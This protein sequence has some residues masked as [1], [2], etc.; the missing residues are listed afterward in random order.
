MKLVIKKEVEQMRTKLNITAEKD[1]PLMTNDGYLV[2]DWFCN[3]FK[4][5]SDLNRF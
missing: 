3:P 1:S 5:K 2:S 4:V